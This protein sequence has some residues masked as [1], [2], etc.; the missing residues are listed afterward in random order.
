MIFG[1]STNTEPPCLET[2]K[3]HPDKL[4]EASGIKYGDSFGSTSRRVVGVYS[5][6]RY[7]T[8]APFTDAMDPM[9]RLAYL[10]Q[11]W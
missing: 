2:G 11:I 6:S 8:L 9:G 1:L 4:P 5:S 3:Q 10:L 7:G